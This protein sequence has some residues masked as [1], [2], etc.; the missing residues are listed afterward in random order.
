M[1]LKIK[2]LEQNVVYVQVTRIRAMK[3]KTVQFDAENEHR[4]RILL[5]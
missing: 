3:T 1:E 4:M 5:L 2:N